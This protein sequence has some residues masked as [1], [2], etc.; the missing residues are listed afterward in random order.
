MSDDPAAL[1][2]ERVDQTVINNI[3]G[4][5][6]IIAG[7]VQ[8]VMQAASIVVLK[9]DLTSL[10]DALGKLGADKNDVQALEKAIAADATIK[11]S[12]GLG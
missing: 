5:H 6:N 9:G 3:Y 10:A 11:A 4:G 8:D 1:P 12:P 2:P 7:R